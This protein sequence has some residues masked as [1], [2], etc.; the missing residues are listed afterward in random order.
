M[1]MVKKIRKIKKE[2]NKQVNNQL[3][4]LKPICY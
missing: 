1:R 3:D 2:N 4:Y